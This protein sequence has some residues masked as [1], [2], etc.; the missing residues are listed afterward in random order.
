[1]D[2][3]IP[4]PIQSIASGNAYL[5]AAWGVGNNLASY[6]APRN[7]Q[8]TNGAIAQKG[9]VH[10]VSFETS[11]YTP[12]FRKLVNESAQTFLTLQKMASEEESKFR[13]FEYQKNL[14]ITE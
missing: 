2:R 12:I 10:T 14:K 4:I 9:E 8:N 3:R 6:S 11:L 7:R 1:M 13:A 5:S